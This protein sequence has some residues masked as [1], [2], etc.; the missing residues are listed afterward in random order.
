[1]A[2]K[3]SQEEY[4]GMVIAK[5][6][7]KYDLSKT[8]YNGKRT[9]IT[10]I[11]KEHGEFVTL[12]FNFL[13]GVGC[14]KCYQRKLHREA[15]IRKIEKAKKLYDNFYDYSCVD[16]DSDN[17]VDIICPIHGKFSQRIKDHINGH[18]CPKCSYAEMSE[19]KKRA[20]SYEML[21]KDGNVVHGGRYAYP[22]QDIK[23]FYEK[24]KIV[25]P[26]HGE[27]E[28]KISAHIADKQGCPQCGLERFHASKKYD[29]K[30]I[31]QLFHDKNVPK[32]TFD[33]SSYESMNTPSLFHCQVCGKDFMRPM[34][35]FLNENDKC[36]HCNKLKVNQE[37]CKTT[38][39]FIKQAK[40]IHGDIYDY[41]LTKYTKSRDYVEIICPEHGKFT[42]EANSHLQGHG[43]PLHH[44]NSS[45][46]EKEV[47]EYVVSLVGEEN[48]ILNSKSILES[49]KELDIFVPS[50]NVAFEFNGLYWHNELNKSA[51]YHLEK[52][53]DCNKQNIHLFHIFEDEWQ[54]KQEIVKSMIKNMLRLNYNKI[55]ARKCKIRIVDSKTAKIFLNNNHLQGNCYGSINLGLFYDNE[56]VSLMVFGSSR[57]FVGNGKTKYELLRFCNK[58]NTHVSGGAS[59]LFSY[60]VKNYDPQEIIS[61]ADKRWSNGNL[62]GV[63][64]FELYNESKPSYYYVIGDKRVYR[65]NLRKNILVE[66]FNCPTDKTEKEFCFEQK[67]YR[68]YDCGCL[69]FKWT[70]K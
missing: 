9:E 54:Y 25:C 24:C 30:T 13:K 28:Q 31:E 47:G 56:L 61:Y 57:H 33:I 42:I 10:V 41:S 53:T 4:I 63:L 65:Y 40:E 60:F 59:K 70:K 36:P 2:K 49:R 62:Y 20:Y 1:M 6:G 58:I 45:K 15:M 52:T 39:E 16:L 43:C 50:C 29:I 14:V 3:I 22:I 37:K 23:Y 66:K 67:W 21:V 11:C 55:Y 19:K 34:T 46:M 17:I 64:G 38:R 5:Y 18:K 68:I 7:D 51:N 44:C 35:V 27:F 26:I 12:P 69:C 48:V 32:I 8:I